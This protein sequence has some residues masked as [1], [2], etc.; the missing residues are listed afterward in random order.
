MADRF[1]QRVRRLLEKRDSRLPGFLVEALLRA[2]QA[3]AVTQG[4]NPDVLLTLAEAWQVNGRTAEA[5]AEARRAL[6]LARS[7]GPPDLVERIEE[8]LRL[9]Q[10]A[11]GHTP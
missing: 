4:Q 5:L 3:K 8:Q 7:T 6:A 9:I 10:R 2:Q 1:Q 11:V